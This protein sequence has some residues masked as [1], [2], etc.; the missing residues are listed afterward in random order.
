MYEKN[1]IENTTNDLAKI[2]KIISNC[3]Q[4]EDFNNQIWSSQKNHELP[5]YRLVE[6]NINSVPFYDFVESYNE[7]D[8]EDLVMLF[9][10]NITAIVGFYIPNDKVFNSAQGYNCYYVMNGFNTISGF[11]PNGSL[12]HTDNNDPSEIQLIVK[13]NDESI[14]ISKSSPEYAKYL[15]GQTKTLPKIL[16]DS[17]DFILVDIINYHLVKSNV[18]SLGK[19]G[20]NQLYCANA[21]RDNRF[22]SEMINNFG[23]D[24]ESAFKSAL[25]WWELNAKIIII[26]TLTDCNS[27][28]L[29]IR[30]GFNT[31]RSDFS[32]LKTYQ[33]PL[34]IDVVDWDPTDFGSTMKYTVFEIDGTATNK[35]TTILS[36]TSFQ[37]PIT[38][39]TFSTTSTQVFEHDSSDDE[40]LDLTVGYCGPADWWDN[41]IGTTG[42]FHFQIWEKH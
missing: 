42:R 26:A 14:K 22:N 40:L 1:L 35:S 37:D 28:G 10:N 23:F 9:N 5:I 13:P 18:T 41:Y 20:C 15:S 6:L 8:H 2:A 12:I 36:S 17:E 3:S 7:I 39:T 31:S 30:K 32:D 29:M 38:G 21:D 27:N 11:S 34:N 33:H 24:N 16:F 4:N 19:S 25:P